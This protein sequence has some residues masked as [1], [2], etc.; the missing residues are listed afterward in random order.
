MPNPT[1]KI[2][3]DD[4][5]IESYAKKYDK[6]ASYIRGCLDKNDTDLEAMLSYNP[7]VTEIL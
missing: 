5:L 4:A 7:D 6:S 3:Y 1:T 2:P